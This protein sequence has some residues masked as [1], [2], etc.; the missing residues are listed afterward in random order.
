MMGLDK[1]INIQPILSIANFIRGGLIF[2]RGKHD[3]HHY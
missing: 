2:D 3:P 1:I